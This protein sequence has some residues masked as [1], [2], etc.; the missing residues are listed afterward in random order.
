VIVP[1]AATAVL[2][3]AVS[4]IIIVVLVVRRESHP[5]VAVLAELFV[6]FEITFTNASKSVL[7][8]SHLGSQHDATRSSLGAC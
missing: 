1:P 4:G 7:R 2:R 3:T 5:V 8:A 6:A